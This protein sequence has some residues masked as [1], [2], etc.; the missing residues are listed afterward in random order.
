MSNAHLVYPAHDIRTEGL[1]FDRSLSHEWLTGALEGVDATPASDLPGVRVRG[2]LSR[3]RGRDIVVRGR[4]DTTL[5]LPC[6]RCLSPVEATVVGELSL[7][8]RPQA[9]GVAR[10]RAAPASSSSAAAAAGRSAEEY[11]FEADEA[12][13]DVYD[14]EAVELDGFVREAILLEVPNFPLCRDDCPGLSALTSDHAEV[15]RFDP[16]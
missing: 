13:F 4:V 16:R 3:S 1:A 11:E 6:A 12:E 2:R 7:L 10:P 5:V 8:L 14:G 9:R 15:A